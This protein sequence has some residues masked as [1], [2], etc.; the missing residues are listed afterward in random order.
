MTRPEC[1]SNS[2][3]LPKMHEIVSGMQLDHV[4][5]ALFASLG[6][7]SDPLKISVLQEMNIRPA[8]GRE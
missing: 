6:M 3:Q 5:Q 8:Q 2:F 7:N 1:A 4:R